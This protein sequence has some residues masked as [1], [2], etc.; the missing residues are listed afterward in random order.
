MIVDH[1]EESQKPL[2]GPRDDQASNKDIRI[3]SPNRII[4]RIELSR[5]I[6]VPN[7]KKKNFFNN[8]NNE[9]TRE[10]EHLMV[11]IS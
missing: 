8:N 2:I 6:R 4:C 3:D 1:S 9:K 11:T 5:L 7:E 10:D